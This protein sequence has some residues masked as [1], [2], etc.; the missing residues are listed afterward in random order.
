MTNYGAF[1][2]RET[3]VSYGDKCIGTNHTLPTNKNAARYTAMLGR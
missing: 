2:D 1:L 3:N